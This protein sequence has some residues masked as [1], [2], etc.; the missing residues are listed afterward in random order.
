MKKPAWSY[1]ALTGFETCPYRYYRTRV[2]KDVTEPQTEALR[3]GNEV[4]KALE[5]HA[6][7]DAPLPTGMDQAGGIIQ[8]LKQ[9]PGELI[10]EQQIAL[11]ANL[12]P[13]DWFAKNTWL[14]GVV[15]FGLVGARNA[16]ALDWKTGKM[17]PDSEQL[18]LFAALLLHAYTQVQKVVTGFVWLRDKK[19]TKQTYT[20]H[21]LGEIWGIFMPRVKR[22]EQAFAD[23]KWPKRPSG[24]CRNYCPVAACEHNGRHRA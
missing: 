20:R 7:T 2:T 11:D 15:D 4:H 17:K 5:Q 8:K 21:D 12:Q 16:V 13:C 22:L 14:R 19:I 9:R 10:V 18:K 24:L 1:T 23:D 6:K 3:W